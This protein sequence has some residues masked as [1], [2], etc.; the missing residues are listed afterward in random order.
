MSIVIGANNY[1]TTSIYYIPFQDNLWIIFQKFEV[2][3]IKDGSHTEG[4]DLQDEASRNGVGVPPTAHTNRALGSYAVP[5]CSLGSYNLCHWAIF[6]FLFHS[7][8]IEPQR[9][10]SRHPMGAKKS[11]KIF[12]LIFP[13]FFDWIS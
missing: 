1:N 12:F 10:G 4:L 7:R 6:K 11:K 9:V 2:P 8:E 5:F 13:F 3:S